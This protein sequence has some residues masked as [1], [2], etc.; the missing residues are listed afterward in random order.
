MYVAICSAL[1]AGLIY[2][3]KPL[4][5]EKTTQL[6]PLLHKVLSNKWYVDEIYDFI[7]VKPLRLFSDITYKLVDRI[8]IDGLFVNGLGVLIDSF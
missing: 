6:L 1:L 4:I 8:I 2:G 7:I 5:A 3:L